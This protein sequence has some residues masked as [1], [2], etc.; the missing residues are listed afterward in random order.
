MKYKGHTI[1]AGLKASHP[2]VNQEEAAVNTEVS[3]I[4]PPEST[5]TTLYFQRILMLHRGVN[6]NVL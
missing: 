2:V 5:F 4:L 3:C 1:Y 6:A